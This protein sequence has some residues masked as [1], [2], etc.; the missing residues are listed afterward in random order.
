MHSLLILIIVF[1]KAFLDHP[2]LLYAYYSRFNFV[3]LGVA[4]L[5]DMRRHFL[6]RECSKIYAKNLARFM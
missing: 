2:V 5:K 4:M 3:M 1:T 6:C